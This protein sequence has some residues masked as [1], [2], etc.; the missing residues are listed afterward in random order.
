[1]RTPHQSTP[2]S[3]HRVS[4]AASRLGMSDAKNSPLLNP[5]AER[6]VHTAAVTT[7]AD[8]PPLRR[9]EDDGGDAK[10][11]AAHSLVMDGDLATTSDTDAIVDSAH[12]THHPHA[13]PHTTT[14][15]ATEDY[16]D[17][18]SSVPRSTSPIH[19]VVKAVPVAVAADS[20]RVE[21]PVPHRPA[22]FSPPPP[23]PPAPAPPPAPPPPAPATSVPK[24]KDKPT[25]LDPMDMR[26]LGA[27]AR[28]SPAR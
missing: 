1:M 6:D 25:E 21:K 16:D 7:N 8:L 5:V 18:G 28:E 11:A 17:P 3:P 20:N 24:R 4:A 15:D 26:S 27:Q 14:D 13:L 10:S 22:A 2:T 23:P 9:R 19:S 12:H